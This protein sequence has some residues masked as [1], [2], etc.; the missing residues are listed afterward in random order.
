ML[1]GITNK[2][3]TALCPIEIRSII[4]DINMIPNVESENK[5]VNS[6]VL[7]RIFSNLESVTINEVY[8]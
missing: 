4:E 2:D 6:A 5:K 1:Q 8:I 7:K 3:G